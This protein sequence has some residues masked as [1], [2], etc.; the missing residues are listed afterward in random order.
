MKKLLLGLASIAMVL[1]SCTK[2]SNQENEEQQNIEIA[3]NFFSKTPL[4][5]CGSMAAKEFGIKKNPALQMDYDAIEEFT[6]KAIKNKSFKRLAADGSIE[7]P[8]V[9]HVIYRTNSENLPTSQLQAQLDAMNE[10]FNLNNPGRNT[11]PAEFQPVESNVNISFVLQDVIRV[12][13]SKKRRWRPDD[14]MKS[15]A[16]G[17][18]NVVNPQEFLNIWVVN[19]MPYQGGQ[20]LGYAQFPGGNWSTDGVVL[21]ANFV[22]GSQRTATH[23]VGHWLNLRH[24]W[25][26]GGCSADDFVADTPIS[27][28]YNT[29]CPSYPDVS[30]NSTDMTMNF[31]DYTSD[32]CMNMFTEGQKD[33]MMTV[34]ASGGFRSG[35]AQ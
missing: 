28:A 16:S 31:M 13:N 19:Y 18:S 27:S 15:T 29:G 22:G 24:I 7:I 30:C 11:I 14:S 8:V 17:G 35:M 33:R 23:E 3:D 2:D 34:F 25:G 12:Q 21:A 10:D 9:F 6:Q 20:I 26:D 1:T 32:S 5:Q 4:E